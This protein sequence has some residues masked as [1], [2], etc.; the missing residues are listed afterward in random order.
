[1]LRGNATYWTTSNTTHRQCSPNTDQHVLCVQQRDVH[2]G[3]GNSR[4]SHI[5]PC[6]LIRT[7]SI[8]HMQT[9]LNIEGKIYSQTVGALSSL[10]RQDEESG[11]AELCSGWIW[12]SRDFC[13]SGDS[14]PMWWSQLSQ[15]GLRGWLWMLWLTGPESLCPKVSCPNW[16]CRTQTQNREGLTKPALHHHHL[17][18]LQLKQ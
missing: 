4:G 13:V 12:I 2:S 1:M 14:S 7:G 15:M 18:I 5:C 16:C 8:P 9:L 11:N 10:F 17:C 6:P 3:P